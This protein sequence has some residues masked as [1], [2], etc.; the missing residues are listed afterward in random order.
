MGIEEDVE[1]GETGD[2]DGCCGT[3]VCKLFFVCFYAVF[4]LKKVWIGGYLPT[5]ASI[6]DHKASQ[7]GF[8]CSADALLLITRTMVKA[9][10][11]KTRPKSIPKPNFCL[12]L[13]CSFKRTFSGRAMTVKS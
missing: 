7:I 11:I 12:L 3:L 1:G 4:F 8:T 6:M 10:M 5:L 9:M 2:H 13:I